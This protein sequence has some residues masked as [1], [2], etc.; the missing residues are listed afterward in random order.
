MLMVMAGVL[1]CCVQRFLFITTMMLVVLVML[2]L[3]VMASMLSGTKQADWLFTVLVIMASI[4]INRRTVGFF[5]V[6]MCMAMASKLVG[7]M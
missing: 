7:R 6:A 2:M 5:A 1:I 3:M 4:L